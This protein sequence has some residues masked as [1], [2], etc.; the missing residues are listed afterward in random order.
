MPPTDKLGWFVRPFVDERL[1]RFLHG[2]DELVVLHEADVNDVIHFVLEVQQLL[3]HR[4]VFLWV[5]DNRASKRLQKKAMGSDIRG[6][7]N[8]ALH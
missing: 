3:H 1:E 7:I 6:L 4:L 5:D 2:V 8:Y